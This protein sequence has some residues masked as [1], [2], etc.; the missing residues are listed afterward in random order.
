MNSVIGIANYYGDCTFFAD[1]V[2][3]LDVCIRG[4]RTWLLTWFCALFSYP[5]GAMPLINLSNLYFIGCYYNLD[6][7]LSITPPYPCSTY[8][9]K[10]RS[11]CEAMTVV[12]MR[13]RFSCYI[14]RMDLYLN[15]YFLFVKFQLGYSFFFPTCQRLDSQTLLHSDSRPLSLL[16]RNIQLL[17]RKSTHLWIKERIPAFQS[18]LLQT[19][20]YRASETMCAI[21]GINIYRLGHTV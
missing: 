6:L 3:T 8:L 17:G 16:F 13:K 2:N 7:F 1:N 9:T 21:M 12:K 19:Y 20:Y 14:S 4:H 5:V 10:E 11:A 18:V 15:L